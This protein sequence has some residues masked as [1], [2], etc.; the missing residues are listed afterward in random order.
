ML[1]RRTRS[2]LFATALAA[3]VGAFA[4]SAEAVEAAP[5]PV[6][7]TPKQLE[8]VTVV[9]HLGERVDPTLAFTDHTGKAVS[10]GDYLS[11]GKPVLLTLNYYSCATLCGVQLNALHGVLKELDW[12]AGDG[13]FRVVTVSINPSESWE[14]AQQKRDNYLSSLG[15]GDE[16]DWNFLVGTD[17]QVRALANQVGF[18]YRY[19][20]ASKQYAHP[21]VLTFLAPDGAVAR[22][23]YG[24]QYTERDLRF[25]LMEAAQG[26]LGSPVDKLILSCFHFDETT[27]RYTA[28]AFGVM[29]VGGVASILMVGGLGLAM[30]RRERRRD[31]ETSS[32][33]S[34]T[35]EISSQEG[36]DS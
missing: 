28:T 12:T 30:W 29:R 34:P 31:D 8:E 25:A 17:D 33:T 2:A 20:E 24:L 6:N 36:S 26:R 22:Y 9:E 21:A 1:L 7:A 5:N 10:L 11:D 4:G 35:T 16:V 3:V 23:V 19:D 13:G 15:R 18:G 14:L 32:R 27:G